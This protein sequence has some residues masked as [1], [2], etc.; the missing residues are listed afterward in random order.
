MKNLM[1][2]WLCLLS[3]SL[4]LL[5]WFGHVT[6]WES[7]TKALQSTGLKG[8]MRITPGRK[9]QQFLAVHC[10]QCALVSSS[11]QKLGAGL[12]EE[13]DKIQCVI[14]MNNAPTAGYE[15]DV[16]SLTSLRVV[17]H[18]SV[19]LLVKNE[20]YYFHQ[21]ANTTYVFWGPDSKMRQDG[22]GQIFNVLLKIAKKY[23]NV[24]M[25]S[26]TSE[27]I[28]YCDQVFQNETGK[29]RMKTGA[30]LSTGFF[31][32][33]LALDVCDSIQIYGMINDN[34]CSQE[35]RSLVPYHYYEQNHVEE[36]RMYRVHE[37]KKRGGHRFITEKAIYAKWAKRHKIAFKHP[38]WSL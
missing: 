26:M 37:H 19:P 36:C 3:L 24:K 32:M 25:Y 20:L 23:P 31:T 21:A 16:G 33:I 12:G 28:E 15:E 13:I 11:G 10:N 1:L 27:K 4:P 2:R 6:R 35:N 34:H 22:K 30:F 38:A 7:R 5:F 18:T 14:R 17:S 9:R 29:N 8:Y